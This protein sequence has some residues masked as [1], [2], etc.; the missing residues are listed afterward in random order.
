MSVVVGNMFKPLVSPH[1]HGRSRYFAELLTVKLKSHP[2][3]L[4]YTRDPVYST[5]FFPI[6]G[7]KYLTLE[8]T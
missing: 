7:T 6:Q 2:T 8:M 5:F 1:L 3:I 4:I